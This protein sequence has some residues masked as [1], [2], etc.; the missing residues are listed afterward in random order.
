MQRCLRLRNERAKDG[1]YGFGFEAVIGKQSFDHKRNARLW[2]SL[3]I[4]FYFATNKDHD[5]A[6]FLP[7]SA[8]FLFGLRFCVN[9]NWAISLAVVGGPLWHKQES[10]SGFSIIRRRQVQNDKD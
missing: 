5:V 4:Q 6:F 3:S 2:C 10:L 1:T 9:S 8:P 7:L